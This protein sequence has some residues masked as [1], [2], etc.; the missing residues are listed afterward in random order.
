MSFGKPTFPLDFPHCVDGKGS[1]VKGSPACDGMTL[2]ASLLAWRLKNELKGFLLLPGI[3]RVALESS[4]SSAERL[5]EVKRG[6]P[7]SQS[8]PAAGTSLPQLQKGHFWRQGTTHSC[9][10][11]I[12]VPAP[13]QPGRALRHPVRMLWPWRCVKPGMS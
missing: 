9:L 2:I 5:Q 1:E 10:E 13:A 3:F 7:S 6:K 4:D 12:S 8:L 11:F